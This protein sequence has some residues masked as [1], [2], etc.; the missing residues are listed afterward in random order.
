MALPF[1]HP[2]QLR[3]SSMLSLSSVFMLC[4]IIESDGPDESENNY[5]NIKPLVFAKHQQHQSRRRQTIRW[6]NS[7]ASQPLC[8]HPTAKNNNNN[9]L[10]AANGWRQS[11]KAATT[12]TTAPS[13]LAQP[14]QQA[15]AGLIAHSG[16]FAALSV[17]LRARA[18]S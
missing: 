10:A 4:A 9:S 6:R 11:T 12:T 2:T 5:N 3:A 18:A 16:S 17:G 13:N 7:G 8:R 15:L 14:Q 1:L